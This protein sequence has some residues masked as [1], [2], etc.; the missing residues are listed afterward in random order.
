MKRIF[1]FFLIMLLIHIFSF[2][3]FLEASDS[4][5]SFL[6]KVK[7]P[8]KSSLPKIEEIIEIKPKPTKINIGET[9]SSRRSKV[10]P[11]KTEAKPIKAP[12]IKA[13]DVIVSGLIWNSDLPQ[14]IIN[15][16]IVTIGDKID[17][18]KIVEIHKDGIIIL[19]SGLKFTIK[20]NQDLT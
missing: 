11:V 7:N 17:N 3:S 10:R 19:F 1:L 14:A 5:E 18:F 9:R 20:M 12:I 13:P 8:F 4:F 15:E 2:N 16:S 6:L